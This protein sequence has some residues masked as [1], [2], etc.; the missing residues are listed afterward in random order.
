M[1]LDLSSY[2][3]IA[4]ALFVSIDVEDYQVLRFSDWYRDFTIGGNNYNALGSLVSVSNS[5]SEL[6]LTESELSI[7]ISGIPTANI[8]SVLDY[9]MKGS[10]VEIYRGIFNADTGASVET[11]VGKFK[12]VVTN[13]ALQEEWD[14]ETRSSSVTILL[15]C[16]SIVSIM[17]RKLAGRYTNPTSMKSF[18]PNDLSMDR[19]PNL[20]ESNFNFG[21][22]V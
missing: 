17:N 21:A 8:S 22:P 9:K 14:N 7:T 2:S 19:V 13:F 11:P 10:A 18:Y 1:S 6:R 20:S 12:G 4:T 15:T 3:N 16:A 5:S